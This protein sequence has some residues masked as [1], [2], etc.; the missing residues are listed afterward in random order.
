[1]KFKTWKSRNNVVDYFMEFLRNCKQKS[2]KNGF[3]GLKNEY[4]YGML[5]F[6]RLQQETGKFKGFR[7]LRPSQIGGMLKP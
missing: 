5:P 4:A 2:N 7:K 6:L 3:A 1:M